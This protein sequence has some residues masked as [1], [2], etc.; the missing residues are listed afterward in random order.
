MLKL[1]EKEELKRQAQQFQKINN[2]TMQCLHLL[3]IF[4]LWTT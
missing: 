4:L 1:K 2:L 3:Y